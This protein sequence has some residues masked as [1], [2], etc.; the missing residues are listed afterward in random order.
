MIESIRVANLGPFRGVQEV[1]LGEGIL[2]IEGRYVGKKGKSNRA[3]KSFFAVDLLRFLLYGRHRYTRMEKIINRT[4]QPKNDP[5]YGAVTLSLPGDESVTALRNYDTFVSRFL[6]ELPSFGG[7]NL[8][9]MKQGELQALLDSTLG[10]TGDDALLTWLVMQGQA[11]G[12]MDLQL[13]QRKS[14]LLS[15]FSTVQYPWEAYYAETSDRVK[16]VTGR[17]ME[18]SNQFTRMADA[19]Q[20]QSKETLMAQLE[21]EKVQKEQLET[22]RDELI[23]ERA[24]IQEQIKKDDIGTLQNTVD[25]LDSKVQSTHSALTITRRQIITLTRNVEKLE[26]AKTDLN[27]AEQAYLKVSEGLDISKLPILRAE[28]QTSLKHNQHLLGEF[29]ALTDRISN[30]DQFQGHGKACPVT[31]EACPQGADI[32]TYRITLV[33]QADRLQ[34]DLKTSTQKEQTLQQE[35]AVMESRVSDAQ[36]LEKHILGLREVIKEHGSA[37]VDLKMLQ[38]VITEQ[39]QA[40][41]DLRQEKQDAEKQLQMARQRGELQYQRMLQDLDN[42]YRTLTNQIKTHEG[43]MAKLNGEV[44]YLN[45]VEADIKMVRSEMRRQED[46]LQVL[47]ALRPALAKDGIPFLGLVASINEF[48]AE[49]N[50]A[51]MNLGSDIRVEVSPYRQ[52]STWEPLCGACGYE[53][54]ST[55][56]KCPVCQELRTRRREETLEIQLRGSAFNVDFQ[57]D[58]GGGKLL[59][60]LAIR[61]ALFSVLRERGHMQGIDFWVMDEVFS[62][63]DMSAKASMLQFMDDLRDMYGFK[64][65]FIISHTDMSEVIPPSIIIERNSETQESIILA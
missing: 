16:Q 59:V 6:L 19:M 12:I 49:I 60:S 58:S 20:L 22:Q 61:L 24:R 50:R 64:Q 45:R 21:E 15:L 54:T 18:L 1:T 32:A 9:K 46:R 56:K 11:N 13:S 62:P 43:N 57:E 44:Q 39:E 34:A 33:N 52:M 5:V 51:L 36:S 30:I 31:G 7:T 2:S 55:I 4:A 3:G 63:L 35:V 29:S 8:D 37:P 40:Y 27:E 10:C 25:M 38:K 53:F 14:F 23:A 42:V 48:E 41:A 26:M 17:Q 47:K 65:L 28:Y